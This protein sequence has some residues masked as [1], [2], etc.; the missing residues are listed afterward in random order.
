LDPEVR[1][2]A[3]ALAVRQGRGSLLEQLTLQQQAQQELQQHAAAL[4]AVQQQAQ[5]GWARRPASVWGSSSAWRAQ[6][7]AARAWGAGAGQ[8]ADSLCGSP[9]VPGGG[10]PQQQQLQRGWGEP[11]LSGSDLQEDVPYE[12]SGWAVAGTVACVYLGVIATFL[13]LCVGDVPY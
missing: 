13:L 7:L 3:E 2:L 9:G 1:A 8:R 4:L 5:Q 11:L 10:L 12:P 6:P